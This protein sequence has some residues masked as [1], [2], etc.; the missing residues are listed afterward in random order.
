ME[1]NVLNKLNIELNAPSEMDGKQIQ[2]DL[3]E[4]VHQEL[5]KKLDKVL[6]KLGKNKR[7]RFSKLDFN[8]EVKHSDDW[9]IHFEQKFFQQLE[10]KVIES[11]RLENQSN[12]NVQ[13]DIPSDLDT[14]LYFLKN[15]TLPWWANHLKINSLQ[16]IFKKTIQEK[17][18]FSDIENFIKRSENALKRMIFQFDDSTLNTFFKVKFQIKTEVSMLQKVMLKALKK[19]WSQRN[20][21]LILWKSIFKTSFQNNNFTK[22]T[23]SELIKETTQSFHSTNKVA[24]EKLIDRKILINHI[25]KTIESFDFKENIDLKNQLIS[26][27]KDFKVHLTENT[28]WTKTRNDKVSQK[29]KTL[30]NDLREKKEKKY[31]KTSTRQEFDLNLEEGIYIDNAGLVILHPFFQYLFKDLGYLNGK[32]F[33]NESSHHQAILLTQYLVSA[34]TKIGE[35]EL[36]LNKILCNFP[37]EQP[38]ESQLNLNK[39]QSELC[40]MLLASTIQHWDALKNTSPEGLQNTFLNREGKLNLLENNDWLLTVKSSAVDVLLSK[41]PWGIGV[42]KLPWMENKLLVEWL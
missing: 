16:E 23:I 40:E 27:K 13:K 42:I 24:K 14:V 2:K 26:L 33:I 38:L 5:I 12:S 41:L 32:E 22:S 21:R 39:K 36:L 28:Q 30:N 8:I 34:E 37:I 4:F 19:Y 11:E 31:N 10:Q 18:N 17:S 20:A 9:L 15:G 7:V 6:S 1:E 35:H 3:S 25:F 29:S